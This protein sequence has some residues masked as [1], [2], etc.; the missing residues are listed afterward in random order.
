VRAF[1]FELVMHSY[2]PHSNLDFRLD[3]ASQ[4]LCK[5]SF[6]D[7]SN[8]TASR[9]CGLQYNCSIRNFKD[10]ISTP[11]ASFDITDIPENF[12]GPIESKDTLYIAPLGSSFLCDA[13]SLAKP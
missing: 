1:V 4:F 6:G 11:V 7:N 8:S 13:I 9:F 2:T 12:V 3:K 10:G 5:Y